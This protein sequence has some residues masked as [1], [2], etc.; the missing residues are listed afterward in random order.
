MVGSKIGVVQLIDLLEK[1]FPSSKLDVL[2]FHS[3]YYSFSNQRKVIEGFG[4]SFVIDI[5]PH[6]R[7]VACVGL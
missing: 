6:A 3:R 1:E 7:S 4:E 5:F 2:L